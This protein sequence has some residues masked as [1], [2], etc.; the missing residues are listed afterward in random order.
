MCEE[1]DRLLRE[2][3]EVSQRSF[4]LEERR[5]H[6]E[7]C[8][9]PDLAKALAS[10]LAALALEQMR[11]SRTLIEHQSQAHPLTQALLADLHL[12]D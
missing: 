1:C 9:E 12:G 6:A 10:R 8:Q 7:L 5:R 3:S 11:T 2:H 4:S